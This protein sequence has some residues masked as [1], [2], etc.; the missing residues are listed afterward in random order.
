MLNKLVLVDL[1]KFIDNYCSRFLSISHPFYSW[2]NIICDDMFQD[3]LVLVA[4]LEH[5]Q[6]LVSAFYIAEL[7]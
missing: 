6:R 1:Y 2:K 7:N 5:Q 4:Q 3:Y